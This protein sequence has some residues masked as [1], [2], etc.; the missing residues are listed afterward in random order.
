MS[1]IPVMSNTDDV[2]YIAGSCEVGMGACFGWEVGRLGVTKIDV[3]R[4][5]GPMGHYPWFNVWKGETLH[6]RVNSIFVETIGY[7]ESVPANVVPLAFECFMCSCPD[8]E[9]TDTIDGCPIYTCLHC[10]RKFAWTGEG[11]SSVRSGED[12]ER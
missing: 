4:V 12:H 6:V 5:E 10:K 7:K 1:E 11:W 8:G 3:I 9:Q 2:Q